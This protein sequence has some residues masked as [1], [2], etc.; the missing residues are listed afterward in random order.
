MERERV[1]S[2]YFLRMIS[3]FFWLPKKFRIKWKR[4]QVKNLYDGI[5]HLKKYV[6][7]RILTCIYCLRHCYGLNYFA[8][9]SSCC[10]YNSYLYTL[11]VCWINFQPKTAPFLANDLDKIGQIFVSLFSKIIKKATTSVKP[12]LLWRIGVKISFFWFDR[13]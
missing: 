6:T 4:Q 12:K 9:L 5:K 8:C 10:H 1:D 7:P 13:H 2:V 11:T 3:T